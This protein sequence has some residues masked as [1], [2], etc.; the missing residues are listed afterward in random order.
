MVPFIIFV[1]LGTVDK[2]FSPPL[3]AFSANILPPPLRLTISGLLTMVF[4][5]GTLRICAEELFA[6]ATFNNLAISLIIAQHKS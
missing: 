5:Y 4:D 2:L 1:K 3:V 6:H